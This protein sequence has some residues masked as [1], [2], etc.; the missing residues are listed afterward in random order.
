MKKASGKQKLRP[1]SNL[2]KQAVFN[3]LGDIEGMLFLD[4]FAGTGQI[5]M[6]AEERG[7]EVI[8]VEKNPKFAEKIRQKTK[9]K[10]VVEDALRFL[11][12]ANIR[13]DVIFADPPYDYE[14][15]DKLIELALKSL[16]KGGTFILE[17]S[18]KLD[19]SAEKK[20]IYGDTALSIWRKEE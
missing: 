19:F 1:T 6:F 10:V 2:V 17:H 20:K 15:Y 3:M 9:G 11:E 16:N 13:A 8:F 7:A 4:L 5:G 14:F 18:K 12:R